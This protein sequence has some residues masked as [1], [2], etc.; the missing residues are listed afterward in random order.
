MNIGTALTHSLLGGTA[1][2][3]DQVVED[4]RD[5]TKRARDLAYAKEGWAQQTKEREAGE[6]NRAAENEKQRK[7]SRSERLAGQTFRTGEA[8]TNID[9]QL[10]LVRGSAEV[11]DEFK[12]KG[13]LFSRSADGKRIIPLEP[14]AKGEM[15]SP[16]GQ[17]VDGTFSYLTGTDKKGLLKGS[18]K[19]GSGSSAGGPKSVKSSVGLTTLEG[20]V[21]TDPATGQ[22][23]QYYVNPQTNRWERAP[24]PT[25]ETAPVV[26]TPIQQQEAAE[27]GRKTANDLAGVFRSDATDFAPWGGSQTAAENFFKKQ[28]L[29]G[30]EFNEQGRLTMPQAEGQAP[31]PSTPAAI[32]ASQKQEASTQLYSSYTPAKQNHV[33]KYISSTDQ[34]KDPDLLFQRMLE[35][36]FSYE[37]LQTLFPAVQ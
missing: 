21:E 8:D 4:W 7:F 31:P 29:N 2:A 16:D 27:F 19:S 3:S 15:L 13:Q 12:D 6:M 36:G 28:Y 22:K 23:L 20:S 17:V 32:P 1:A 35:L 30:T 26:H 33:Q 34:G 37:E 5:K 24:V 25:R 9:R 11:K 14:D 10:S 18:S